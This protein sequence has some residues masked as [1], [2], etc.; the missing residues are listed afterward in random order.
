MTSFYPGPSQVYDQVPAY[1]K[2]AYDAG[3]LGM[4]HRSDECMALVSETQSL[5]RD[6]LSI[7]DDYHIYFVSSATECWEI[8]AQSLAVDGSFHVFNGAF[9]Q[10]WFDYTRRISQHATSKSFDREELIPISSLKPKAEE[11][12]CITQNE[13]SNGTQVNL[14]ELSQLRKVFPANLIAIDATSS[15][16]G[17]EL[18]FSL[19]DIWFSSVQKCFGLPAGLAILISS[20]KAREKF[21]Q[22]NERNYYNSLTFIDEMMEKNQT[23]YTPNVLG[24]Y[25]LMRSLTDRPSIRSTAEII[26][27]RFSEWISFIEQSR[28]QHLIANPEARSYTVIPIRSE[29]QEIIKIKSSAK[30]AGFLLGEGYGDLKKNTFRIANFPALKDTELNALREFLTNIS[31]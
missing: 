13:T 31:V 28:F 29:Q 14:K 12:I 15:M 7:P 27:G 20:P 6:R 22:I 2:D 1:V 9:G 30:A 25:L 19:G 17:I 11:V 4:N 5:L 16:A 8:I 3:V 24:I 21:L 26:R 10:K 18:N 23:P